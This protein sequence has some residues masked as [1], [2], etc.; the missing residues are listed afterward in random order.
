MGLLGWLL[1]AF[2]IAGELVFES[3]VSKADGD[4]Q[5][6][7]SKLIEE[8]RGETAK[9][10]LRAKVL[11][12]KLKDAEL[13]LLKIRLKEIPRRLSSEQRR[14][15]A[16]GLSQFAGQWVT[17]QWRMYRTESQDLASDLL[18]AL[19]KQG[20]NWNAGDLTNND[21]DQTLGM[22]IKVYRFATDQTII[23]S[24]RSSQNPTA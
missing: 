1:V 20:A 6:F 13:A 2:G 10:N 21:A 4:V 19:G 5:T 11:D 24:Y 15:L 7:E 14:T 16:L 3:K 17:I 8:G 12:L 23:A 18:L 22:N 9:L